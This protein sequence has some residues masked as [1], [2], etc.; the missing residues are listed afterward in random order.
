MCCLSN[1]SGD[2]YDLR[3]HIQSVTVSDRQNGPKSANNRIFANYSQI[4]HP[5]INIIGRILQNLDSSNKHA[6]TSDK[7]EEIS[8][9]RMIISLPMTFTKRDQLAMSTL[10]WPH[11]I[12]VMICDIDRF[13]LDTEPIFVD[14]MHEVTCYPLFK[15][16]HLRLMG[17]SGFESAPWIIAE[18]NLLYSTEEMVQRMDSALKSRLGSTKGLPRTC[19]FLAN[20]EATIVPLALAKG[21]NRINFKTKTDPHS[22]FFSQFDAATWAMKS[23]RGSRTQRS[24]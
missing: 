17:R 23:P 18:Y 14:P 6:H 3:F 9:K 5:R 8:E 20:L 21:S 19:D 22:E 16:F 15:E 11:P 24:S 1:G 13:L 7:C 2:G 4:K 12:T 10:V